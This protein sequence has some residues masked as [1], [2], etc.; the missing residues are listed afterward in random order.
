MLERL[1][2]LQGWQR[3]VETG[4]NTSNPVVL[5]STVSY[6]EHSRMPFAWAIPPS[7]PLMDDRYPTFF[8]A[9]SSFNKP[10][11]RLS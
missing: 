3:L 2:L 9:C 4:N 8:A 6:P 10:V 1:C 7:I 11:S 5:A